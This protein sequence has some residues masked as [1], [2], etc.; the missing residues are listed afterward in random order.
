VG[1]KHAQEAY[2][3]TK[4]TFVT[5]DANATA[6]P[7]QGLLTKPLGRATTGMFTVL[8]LKKLT[9]FVKC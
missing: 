4:A 9:T 3:S 1:P 6:G 2:V 7:L 8:G 5:V